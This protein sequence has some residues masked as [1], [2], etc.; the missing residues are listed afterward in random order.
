MNRVL[1]LFFVCATSVAAWATDVS[2]VIFYRHPQG[3]LAERAVVINV[4]E[5]GQ[6]DVVLSGQGFEWRS[7]HFRA[8]RDEFGR[9][10]FIVH[11]PHWHNGQQFVT[12]LAGTYMRTSDRVLY[13]GDVYKEHGHHNLNA[14]HPGQAQH[15]G[16]F[17]FDYT[18]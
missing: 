14:L 6:G 9:D 16:G 8:F 18:R 2:G 11:F 10:V 13:F 5:R 12:T 3:T 7:R 15:V 4:P 1:S 17:R